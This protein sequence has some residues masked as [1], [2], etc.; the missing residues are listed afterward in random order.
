MPVYRKQFAGQDISLGKVVG[1]AITYGPILGFSSTGT[2]FDGIQYIMEQENGVFPATDKEYLFYIDGMEEEGPIFGIK[3]FYQGNGKA[4][5]GYKFRK[6]AHDTVLPADWGSWPAGDTGYQIMDRAN[7]SVYDGI[8][9]NNISETDRW[10]NGII[11]WYAD[12]IYS[13][14]SFTEDELYGWTLGANIIGTHQIRDF[15]TC[16][17][18]LD[19]D[20]SPARYVIDDGGYIVVG[21]HG[22]WNTSALGEVNSAISV[23]LALKGIGKDIDSF[24]DDI[25]ETSPTPGGNYGHTPDIIGIP[26]LPSLGIM[27]SGMATMWAPNKAQVKALAAFLWSDDYHDNVIKN[28]NPIENIIQF[29]VVPFPLTSI[30]G[31]AR[32]VYVGNVDTEVQMDPLTQQYIQLDFGELSLGE[33]FNS[34]MDYEPNTTMLCYLPYVGTFPIASYEVYNCTLKLV[35]NVDLYSG[36]FTAFI[37]CIKGQ[38]TSVLYEHSGN[39]ML[40]LPITGA[41]YSQYYKNQARNFMGFLG[42]VASGNPV[43]SASALV[44]S[45]MSQNSVDVQRTGTYSGASAIMG[46]EKAYI[47][48][49]LPKQHYPGNYYSKTEGMPLYLTRTLSDLKGFT[50]VES[51]IDNTVTAT[52]TEKAEIEKLLKEGII[53][54]YN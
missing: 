40:Q 53:L 52:D 33:E 42:G 38:L 8:D 47:I 23:A 27:D 50:K 35:Y 54:P 45:A 15:D 26:G 3:V 17:Y 32:N 10:E 5:I 30:T 12:A 18:H 11:F 34:S 29:G 13:A 48:I 22:L 2:R 41:N 49:T 36:D 6:Q 19:T 24:L 9:P 51:V 43:Q 21:P 31:T 28:C 44:D 1:D 16:A 7:N 46:N 14:M 39:L 25:G 4:L 37:Y 20:Q